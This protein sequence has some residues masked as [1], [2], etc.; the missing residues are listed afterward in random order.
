MSESP[1]KFSRIAEEL[2]ADL[3]QVPNEQPRR[4]R[5]RPTKPIA[6]VV[7]DLVTKHRIGRTGPEDAIRE[8]WAEI[9]GNASAAY[10]HPAR[11]EKEGTVL[12]VITSH[13]VVRNELFL[14]RIAI[15]G[16]LRRLP[17][18]SGI[19]RLHLAAG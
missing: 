15:V 2:I 12:I 7:E 14:N 5:I 8:R 3:R 13:S 4:Q 11:L 9:V 6:D 1:H 19:R 17:G 10:S 18:C 16:K